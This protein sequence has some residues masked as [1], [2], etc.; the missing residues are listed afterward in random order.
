MPALRSCLLRSAQ[1]AL[2][3]LVTACAQPQPQPPP[4]PT[5]VVNRVLDTDGDGVANGSDTCVLVP[6]ADQLPVSDK[7]CAYRLRRQPLDAGQP[8]YGF[9]ATYLAGDLNGDG[10]ADTVLLEGSAPLV[11]LAADDGIGSTLSAP[12]SEAATSSNHVYALGDVDGDGTLDL[13]SPAPNNPSTQPLR[14]WL[15]NGHGQFTATPVPVAILEQYR[16]STPPLMV[17]VT[18]DGRDDILDRQLFSGD[19]A[20]AVAPSVG[21]WPGNESSDGGSGNVGLVRSAFGATFMSITATGEFTGDEHVDLLAYF[22]DTTAGTVGT[23]RVLH[24]DGRGGFTQGQTLYTTSG[25]GVLTTLADV[26][27]D[28]LQDIVL[29]DRTGNGSLSVLFRDPAGYTQ[30][31]VPRNASLPFQLLATPFVSDVTGDGLPDISVPAFMSFGLAVSV[32]HGRTFDAPVGIA[33][34]YPV[35]ST[36]VQVGGRYTTIE[37]LATGTNF[38]TLKIN[39]P[40]FRSW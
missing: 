38:V 8:F 25:F 27:R 7:I 12:F 2:T 21:P 11:V 15:G 26:D 17:D 37:S 29:V 5:R 20:V 18:G 23:L 16:E 36:G 34:G 10:R 35:G 14:A 9:H 33:G 28:G 24:G 40:G 39:P 6:N 1:C 30:V 3:L 32:G 4:G 13:V 31:D 19:L 22:L